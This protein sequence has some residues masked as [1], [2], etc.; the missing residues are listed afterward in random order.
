[1]IM[2]ATP[3]AAGKFPLTWGYATLPRRTRRL[4]RRAQIA[5]LCDHRSEMITD[6]MSGSC[7]ADSL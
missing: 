6:Q 1:M 2:V 3:F 4:M 5:R 7:P